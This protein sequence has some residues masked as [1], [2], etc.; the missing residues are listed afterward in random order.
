MHTESSIL[1]D[2]SI[3]IKGQGKELTQIQAAN[4]QAEASDRILH[5][6]NVTVTIKD[7]GFTNGNSSQSGGAILNEG[8]LEIINTSFYN[9][10]TRSTNT[11][12]DGGGAIF[13]KGVLAISFS[14]FTNNY[15][16]TNGGAI[17][18]TD[19]NSTLLL[20][21]VIIDDNEAII[22]GGGIGSL[23]S[24]DIYIENS[25]IVRNKTQQKG[26]GIA[27]NGISQLPLNQLSLLGN[28]ISENTSSSEGGGL[29]MVGGDLII[30]NTIIAQNIDTNNPAHSDVSTYGVQTTE[31]SNIIGINPTGNARLEVSPD[32]FEGTPSEPFNPELDD[33]Y[34]PLPSSWAI[35]YGQNL[36]YIVEGSVDVYNN[37]R[38]FA[39]NVEI[40]DIGAV[41]YQDEP[42]PKYIIRVQE[43]EVEF[44]DVPRDVVSNNSVTIENLGTTTLTIDSII[45][46][47]GFQ[48][49]IDDTPSNNLEQFTIEP[50]QTQD[51][52]ISLLPTNEGEYIGQAII[53]SNADNDASVELNL[54]ANSI[55]NS[56]LFSG[57]ITEDTEWCTT[58]VIVGSNVEIK[59]NVTLTICA[60]TVI[61]MADDYE[62]TIKGALISNG[63]ALDSVK[64]TSVDNEWAGLRFEAK[65]NSAMPSYLNYTV[66]QNS[67]ANGSGQS[68]KGG[69]IYLNREST[70]DIKN[71]TIQ[72][73]SATDVGGGIY[74]EGLLNLDS[75]NIIGNTTILAA[76]TTEVK[77]GA[78]IMNQGIL[79]L[80]NSSVTNNH[81]AN[82]GGGIYNSKKGEL[83]VSNT[84]ISNNTSYSYGGGI[85]ASTFDVLELRNC[86]ITGNSSDNSDGGGIAGGIDGEILIINTTIADNNAILTGGGLYNFGTNLSLTNSIISDNTGGDYPDINSISGFTSY[87]YNIIRNKGLF[88]FPIAEGDII[89]T[90]EQPI[91]PRL[92]DD[93][94]LEENSIALNNGTPD[95]A[96]LNLPEKDLAGMP[97]IFE[98]STPLIDM[99]PFEYQSDPT[100][101]YFLSISNDS[102]LFPVTQNNLVSYDSTYLANIS[103]GTIEI[104]SMT[105]PPNYLISIDGIN[106]TQEITETTTILPDDTLTL[107][108]QFSPLDEIVYTGN[109]VINSN[110]DFEPEKNIF[111]SGKGNNNFQLGGIIDTDSLVCIAPGDTINITENLTITA[112]NTLEFC[113]GSIV[114]V[115]KD[116]HVNVEG[117]LFI[118]GT[119]NDSIKFF[120][121]DPSVQ[122]GGIY[123]K[124][125]AL[126]TTPSVINYATF[127]NSRQT[128][129]GAIHNDIQNTLNISHSIFTN[130]S[131]VKRG[132]A[133]YNAG[134]MTIDSCTISNNSTDVVWYEGGGGLA[135]YGNLEVSNTTISDNFSGHHGGGVYAVGGG[136]EL[137]LNNCIITNNTA[138][139]SGGGIGCLDGKSI[140]IN[141]CLIAENEALNGKGGGVHTGVSFEHSL[142]I[143]NSSIT[144]NTSAGPGG[145]LFTASAVLDISHTLIANNIMP[146]ESDDYRPDIFIQ[147]ETNS[148]GYNFIGNLGRSYWDA[149][150]GDIWGTASYPEDP[151]LDADHKPTATS[152]IANM[153]DAQGTF[154]DSD[155]DYNARIYGGIIDMGAYEFQADKEL[156]N[157]ILDL[158]TSAINFYA[159]P[160]GFKTEPYTLKLSNYEAND[161]I[162]ISSLTVPTGY[163][164]SVNGS[165][166]AETYPDEILIPINQSVYVDIVFEPTNEENYNGIVS[167]TSND[168]NFP[169][170]EIPISGIGASI[171][172]SFSF[173]D[174]PPTI[175][176]ILESEWNSYAYQE[177]NVPVSPVG[178]LSTFV[179]DL[180]AGYRA[181]W[182][183]DSLYLIVTIADDSLYNDNANPALNDNVELYLDFNN[184]KLPSY[185]SD[186]YFIRFVWDND[187][188]IVEN[189]SDV[190]DINFAQNTNP[191]SV[192]YAFEM[193]IPWSSLSN[194]TPQAGTEIGIDINVIDNDGSGVEQIL[195][196]HSGATD[197]NTN[198]SVFGTAILLDSNG[199]DPLIPVMSTNA[200]NTYFNIICE[201]SVVVGVDFTNSGVGRD[202]EVYSSNQTTLEKVLTKLNENY[203]KVTSLIPDKYNFTEG[204][205]SFYI[206]DGGNNMYEIGNYLNTNYKDKIPYSDNTIIQSADFGYKSRYFTRKV[207]GMFVAAIDANELDYFE[208]NGVAG[209]MANATHSI[210]TITQIFN[211]NKYKG[212]IKKV[213]GSSEPSINQLIITQPNNRIVHTIDK[214]PNF[215][216]HR[217]DSLNFTNRFYYILFASE[218]GGFVPN[219][220]FEKIMYSFLENVVTETKYASIPAGQTI[221]IDLSVPTSNLHNGIHDNIIAIYSNDPSNPTDTIQFTIEKAGIPDIELSQRTINFGEVIENHYSVDTLIVS[222]QG[223]LP[224]EISD[225]TSNNTEFF[226][227]NTS[228]TVNPDAQQ[229]IPVYFHPLSIG[230]FVGVLNIINNDENQE[231]LLKGVTADTIPPV[232]TDAK[233]LQETPKNVTLTFNEPV[234]FESFQGFTIKGT[235]GALD[236]I[237]QLSDK[238]LS[239][240]LSEEVKYGHII[241]LDYDDTLGDITDAST[242]LNPLASFTGMSVSNFVEYK[243]EVPPTLIEARVKNET[244]FKVNLLFNENVEALD[245][246]GI[247]ISGTQG[248]PTSID[249]DSTVLE[250]SMDERMF[251]GENLFFDYEWLTGTITDTAK[252]RLEDVV[253]LSIINDVEYVD[254]IAPV[255]VLSTVEDNT[256]TLINLNFSEPVEIDDISGFTLTGT[257]GSIISVSGSGTEDLTLT[258]DANVVFGEYLEL[259]YTAAAGS[260]RDLWPSTPN[261]TLDFGPVPV[262]NN[263][264]YDGTPPGDQPIV[265]GS[266]VTNDDPYTV[267]VEFSEIVYA[268]DSSGFTISGTYANITKSAGS[269]TST[270]SFTIDNPITYW[271]VALLSYDETLGDVI[272][273]ESEILKSFTNLTI[274]NEVQEID[275][276]APVVLSAEVFNDNPNELVLTFDEVVTFIDISGFTIDGI[277][278][279]IQSVIG[280]NTN[281]MT[282]TLDTEVVFGDA[283]KLSYNQSV[284]NVKDVANTP[285]SLESFNEMAVSNFVEY[286]DNIKPVITAATVN[287]DTPLEITLTFSEPVTYT[288][289]VGFSY[290]GSLGAIT[291]IQGDG[292]NTLSL[293]LDI[294]I[295]YGESIILNYIDGNVTDM[296]EVPNVLDN[297]NGLQ[298]TNLVAD[299][300]VNPLILDASVENTTPNVI[301][302]LFNEIVTAETPNGFSLIGTPAIITNASGNNTNTLTFTTDIGIAHSDV[303]KLKYDGT[304][305]I[306]DRLDNPLLPVEYTIL[307]SVAPK[308]DATLSDLT[309]NGVTV[310]QFNPTVLTYNVTIPAT[311]VDIPTV[312]GVTSDVNAS[313]TVSQAT[314]IE[315]TATVVVTAEDEVATLTYTVNLTLAESSDATLRDLTVDGETVD[316]FDPAIDAYIVELP[317]SQTIVPLVEATPNNIDAEA[318]VTP[319]GSVPGT[320]NIDVTAEDDTQQQYTVQFTQAAAST[321]ATLSDL[322]VD[323][324]TIIGFDPNTRDYTIELPY[325]TITVPEV[326]GVANDEHAEVVETP[327]GAL[328]GTSTVVVT[329][330]DGLTT[331]TYNVNFTYAA[332]TDATLSDLTIDGVTIEGFDPLIYTYSYQI[333]HDAVTSPVVVATENDPNA[334][335]SI[336]APS[337]L[338]GD[339]SITV[340]AEDGVTK[341]VYRITFSIAHSNDATLSDL[342]SDGI[343]V[344]HFNSL[345]KKY[346]IELPYGTTTMPVVS[347]VT[348]DDAAT[349]IINQVTA[350]PGAATVEVT[351]EDLISKSTY[352]INYSVAENTDATLSSILVDNALIPGFDPSKLNYNVE[353]P[354][355]TVDVPTVI[356][357]PTDA[358]ATVIITDASTVNG[359]TRIKVTAEDGITNQTYSVKF[360]VGLNTDATLSDLT[361]NGSTVDGFDP[362]TYSYTVV[363]PYG[364]TIVP[365]VV[366]T[367]TDDNAALVMST[368]NS[369][370][371]TTSVNVTAHDGETKLQYDVIFEVEPNTDATL[372][373]ISVDDVVIPDFSSG[374]F[375]YFYVVEQG[376]TE[377]PVV[378]AVAT[379]ANAAI[380]I[381]D[382]NTLPGTTD[383][384]VTAEDETTV[385]NYSVQF[386][387]GTK[388]PGESIYKVNVFPNPTSEYL[389]IDL[390]MPASDELSYEIYDISGARVYSNKIKANTNKLRIDV[391]ELNIGI[392]TLII[393]S[394]KQKYVKRIMIE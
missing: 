196:W 317:Y 69:G 367:T 171:I 115:N 19:A 243:D 88:D 383:I 55:D 382:A 354:Y 264:A 122:W 326:I 226:V 210:D 312:D 288:D 22:N 228:W 332:N 5:I 100:L 119:E 352:T 127:T 314:E 13:N 384:E 21:N 216:R 291:G 218:T 343:T 195:A 316:G 361:V 339:M 60:G 268:T 390:G 282:F 148:L 191:N 7:I 185:G 82:D 118:T 274:V 121:E 144:S 211:G 322:T 146:S 351:A 359:T 41:E 84:T 132:G 18:S 193:A 215:N 50:Q 97:R 1:I 205:T 263:V 220:D 313:Y 49:S 147:G 108:I 80:S 342:L 362:N 319:T 290:T 380:V 301:T 184:S 99:G 366:A 231:I 209:A 187:T 214:N 255:L 241:T 101:D 276:D 25:L 63:T 87:G 230:D 198:P 46:N 77:G 280:D 236:G 331:L 302:V 36:S 106:Y 252:N 304:G 57:D 98:G 283:L 355:G 136:S 59:E 392:H 89:G 70:V 40:V 56:E 260:I 271:D 267:L 190:T 389:N 393:K 34:T 78:G 10:K 154:G 388:L 257:T 298:V 116:V 238:E 376:E 4:S 71:S 278:A 373:S 26:G 321:D 368:A 364:T 15:S 182:T 109:I 327:A 372:Q 30:G 163:L 39:G 378:T 308:T 229:K 285:N 158:D 279:N 165:E 265:T 192:A 133:I 233:V 369:L 254:S 159:Q 16:N 140:E 12:L 61:E 256:P 76:A 20:Q 306:S 370:P 340:T 161:Y 38:I 86:L 54:S 296:A 189:G 152:L 261:F 328:P 33:T 180:A 188:Y 32:D 239:L 24:G 67:A 186:D 234:T 27:I 123:Y 375:E 44:G 324:T 114:K 347:A 175:D 96:P 142:I 350:L 318:V 353:L 235:T 65:K 219:E 299:E 286:V 66:I 338:P 203:T 337:S 323:G 145:G 172:P 3:N 387:I 143:N 270:L 120:S 348:S 223:C 134:I 371:G 75:V 160:V 126:N 178:G 90:S 53:Y 335:H 251:H 294:P 102:I 58:R 37:P 310:P 381:T 45:I 262:Q 202:L 164:L 48:V 68:V 300:F 125:N 23:I 303:P 31:G 295:V 129:G 287:N 197:K 315:G 225:I 117:M 167:I 150:T 385:L 107:T 149:N 311:T 275:N 181:T 386:V 244:P 360:S 247:T 194:I 309:V 269:G 222:N 201:D 341:L 330:E 85:F 325:G 28:T 242:L 62:F 81:S 47:G 169:I 357:Y 168:E 377:I 130:N 305:D 94:S 346:N 131:T 135:N 204:D 51:I 113:A 212:F 14:D 17:W 110:D 213:Y 394:D 42:L 104:S 103:T 273:G 365:T 72:Y 176:G 9:N 232:L 79:N 237:T 156:E 250:I 111:V 307:N 266:S 128:N 95:I 206:N 356:A 253:G 177:I 166:L 344:P 105:A 157:I 333:A 138:T 217:I 345:I 349:T 329:A 336:S 29:Y 227:L 259:S 208:V 170:Q 83:L 174:T 297:I 207:E 162:T 73:N 173:V 363:V 334:S 292:T 224:L 284:G 151:K 245:I 249:G 379:D 137:T 139:S 155:L 320:T 91:N 92:K 93:Y 374:V 64:F 6:A 8:N 200:D 272:N 391:S 141:Q 124:Y 35:N 289:E 2:K 179:A 11:T 153:G 281:T 240:S 221:G 246:S 358:N 74:N 258:L 52:V 199:A 293:T 277:T 248:T 43:T 183:N 112:G